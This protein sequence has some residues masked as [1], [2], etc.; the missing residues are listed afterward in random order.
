MYLHAAAAAEHRRAKLSVATAEW[1][2]ARSVARGREGFA[3]WTREREN[4]H[5]VDLGA[6]LVGDSSEIEDVAMAILIP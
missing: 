3:A 4:A 6:S 1:P 2:K 5:L